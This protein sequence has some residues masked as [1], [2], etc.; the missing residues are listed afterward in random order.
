MG[1]VHAEVDYVKWYVTSYKLDRLHL[2]RKWDQN[3]TGLAQLCADV[4]SFFHPLP[5]H[6][7]RD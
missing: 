6:A 7:Q 4:S 1:A 5:R 3:Q 2:A